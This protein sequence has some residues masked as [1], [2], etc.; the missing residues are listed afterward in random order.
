[1]KQRFLILLTFLMMGC[2]SNPTPDVSGLG[3]R[4]NGVSYQATCETFSQQ[5][6]LLPD[7]T[8]V[9]KVHRYGKAP[10]LTVTH[11][12]D[13]LWPRVAALLQTET[14]KQVKDEFLPWNEFDGGHGCLVEMNVRSG[15]SQ[16]HL[17]EQ[18]G[19]LGLIRKSD[20]AG[21]LIADLLM[22]YLPPVP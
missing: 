21:R 19:S 8:M 12:H 22:P 17:M 11:T 3:A 9:R 5:L 2:V 20:R 18:G 6:F 10:Q 7:G 13:D 1:M 15:A 14:G 16:A 4:A